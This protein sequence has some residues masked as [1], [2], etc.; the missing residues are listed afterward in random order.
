ML[1]IVS[2]LKILPS[3]RSLPIRTRYSNNDRLRPIAG[4]LL[5]ALFE[6]GES[7]LADFDEMLYKFGFG[8]DVP[9]Q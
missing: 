3:L 5:D 4:H 8:L 6:A 7:F 2:I 9:D 1:R